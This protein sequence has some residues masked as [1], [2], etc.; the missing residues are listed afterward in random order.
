MVRN[1]FAYHAITDGWEPSAATV[2]RRTFREH[3]AALAG[4]GW[5]GVSL[6]DAV[7]ADE[8][9]AL[10]ADEM[11]FGL[12][13]DD[14]NVS[15]ATVIVPE[16]AKHG[17]TGTAFIPTG[18]VGGD[19]SWDV[20][21][22]RKHPHLD[23]SALRDVLAAGWEIGT[24]GVSHHALTDMSAADAYRELCESRDMVEQRLGLPVDSMAYPFGAVSESL[25]ELVRQAGY[26]RAVGMSPGPVPPD[27][28]RWNLPRWP[29][30]RT[31]KPRHL[32]ARMSGPGWTKGI[33]RAR[34]WAVHQF[35]IG[36]RIR[37][38]WSRHVER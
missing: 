24:H 20:G 31:D 18:L 23:W 12:T 21:A 19:G 28:G 33:E 17:W 15:L 14:G 30:Y 25:V 38:A 6:C 2:S 13:V 5:R 22:I 29:V 8:S 16:C 34:A 9:E 1:I 37:M 4:D 3:C 36:T 7:P 35:A 26:E 27:A 32:R 10:D 11:S